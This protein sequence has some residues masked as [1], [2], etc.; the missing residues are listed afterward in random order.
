MNSPDPSVEF[1]ITRTFNAPRELVFKTMIETEH[2]QH[3]WGPKECTIDLIKH[4]PRVG[5]I[6]HYCMKFAP[7]VEMHGLFQ[8]REI[9][10]V[11]RLV[12]TNGFADAE[13]NRIRYA[14]SPTWPVEV[15]ITNTLTESDGKTTLTMRS[16]PVNASPIEIETFKAGHASM[17]EGFGGMYDRYAEY[18]ASL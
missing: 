16:E 12:F 8:Y 5:G 4:E 13:G 18:L 11:E 9:T 7:G 15:L 14:M 2:L 10:P 1:V 3:W 17:T 6:F